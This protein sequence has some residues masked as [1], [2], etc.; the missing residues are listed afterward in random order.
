MDELRSS[1]NAHDMENHDNFVSKFASLS[2]QIFVRIS[3]EHENWNRSSDQLPL[4]CPLIRA[5]FF[6]ETLILV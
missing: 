2:M 6:Q 4:S 3:K 5:L 1:C